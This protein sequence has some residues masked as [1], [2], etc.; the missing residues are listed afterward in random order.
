VIVRS[1]KAEA[2]GETR[3]H[4]SAVLAADTAGFADAASW[5]DYLLRSV[6]VVAV[7]EPVEFLPLIP[8]RSA[9]ARI[10]GEPIA[11]MG[12]IHPRVLESLGVPVP[13]AWA[14]V[15]LTGLWALVRRHEVH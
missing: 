3:Y 13:A 2:G 14:E 8:G 1:E 12:E 15:D 5:V 4:A 10:A 9:R 6:D 7:R 11:E